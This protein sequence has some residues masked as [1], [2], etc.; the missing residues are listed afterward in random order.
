MLYPIDSV[1][2]PEQDFLFS[3][4][5]E[6]TSYFYATLLTPTAITG[7]E[8]SVDAVDG[9]NVNSVS[10]LPL[11]LVSASSLQHPKLAPKLIG[12]PALCCSMVSYQAPFVAIRQC[13]SHR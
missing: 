11:V 3:G 12:Q 9:G 1:L 2:L 8:A 10:Q 5:A 13:R 6:L 7:P 4:A